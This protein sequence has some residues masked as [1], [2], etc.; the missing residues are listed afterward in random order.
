[1]SCNRVNLSLRNDADVMSSSWPSILL[2]YLSH[3][4]KQSTCDMS[5]LKI[6]MF[7]LN[8]ARVERWAL[9]MSDRMS[10]YSLTML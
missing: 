7:C 3:P 2:G 5:R 9:E 8:E 10:F 1:M 6:T 4:L